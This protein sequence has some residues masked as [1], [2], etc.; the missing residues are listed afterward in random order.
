[1]VLVGRVV[2]PQDPDVALVGVQNGQTVAVQLEVAAAS[3]YLMWPIGVLLGA[4][5]VLW[6]STGVPGTDDGHH[7]SAPG[8]ADSPASGQHQPAAP[9]TSP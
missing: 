5:M 4:V 7:E 6:S 2:G 3:S 1:M 9:P 8:G